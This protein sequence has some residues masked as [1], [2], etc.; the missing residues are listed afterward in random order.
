LP[1]PTDIP[2]IK[3]SNPDNEEEEMER[4]ADDNEPFA[5]LA[6]KIATD[7][8]VGTLTFVRVYSGVLNSGDGV[9]NSVKGKKERV[10]RMVQMHANARE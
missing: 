9:I 10:G 7:P 2:A 3:G 4:H 5:A 1:A 8:F 6:F